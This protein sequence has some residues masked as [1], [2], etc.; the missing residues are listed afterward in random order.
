M[1]EA[2]FGLVG[3]VLGGMIGI[4]GQLV[5]I[6]LEN[7]KWKKEKLIEDLRIKKHNLE[8]KYAEALPEVRKSLDAEYINAEVALDMIHYFPENVQDAFRTLM[9]PLEHNTGTKR[10]NY[11]KLISEVKK[12]LNNIDAEIKEKIEN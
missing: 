5:S 8:N 10:S 4:V 1:Q 11:F 7:K 2:L 3:V 9:N 12:S 6:H